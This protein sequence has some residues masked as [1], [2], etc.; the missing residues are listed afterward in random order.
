MKTSSIL[1]KNAIRLVALATIVAGFSGCLTKDLYEP[2]PEPEPEE[3]LF[4]DFA[5]S[6]KLPLTIDYGIAD[7]R[8]SFELYDQNPLITTEDDTFIK[9][10][11]LTPLFAA[12]TNWGSQYSGTIQLP[13]AVDKVYLYTDGF[14]VPNAHEIEVTSAGISFIQ[15]LA[16]STPSTREVDYTF[17]FDYPLATAANPYAVSSPL[18]KWNAAGRI[19]AQVN[20]SVI[21]G[22][23]T[24]VQQLAPPTGN[25][26]IYA[27]GKQYTNLV[28][29][30]EIVTHP[31]TGLIEG[32]T[33]IKVK[34]LWEFAGY[35]NTLGYYY[36]PK[37][38][39]MT[40]EAFKRLPKYIVFPNVSWNEVY[41]GNARA[42]LR[43]DYG[44]TPLVEGSSVAL[45]YYG[46]D[47]AQ[48]GTTL[49]PKDVEVGW[50]MMSDAFYTYDKGSTTRSHINGHLESNA[51]GNKTHLT[52]MGGNLMTGRP[53]SMYGTPNYLPYVFSNE[54]FNSNH[55]AGCITLYDEASNTVVIG[56][57]DG[58]ARS[59]Q[60]FLFYVE[61]TPGVINPGWDLTK[62]AVEPAM[63]SHFSGA[64]AFE[65]YWPKK[66]DYDLN[67]VI[68]NYHSTVVTDAD[69]HVIELIDTLKVVNDGADALYK[70]AFGYELGI[71]PDAIE[72]VTIDRKGAVSS[73]KVDAKGLELGQNGM[74]VVML[75]DNHKLSLG[76]SIVVHTKIKSSAAIKLGSGVMYPPYNPF[77]I[78]QASN[79]SGI[80]RKEIH[81][82]KTYRP[83]ALAGGLGTGD[84]VS[85][86]T[87]WYISKP[88]NKAIQYPFA[89][90]VPFD[91]NYRSFI[92]PTEGG[93]I[94]DQYPAFTDWVKSNGS[95]YKTWYKQHK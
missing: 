84:D 32:G 12:Y 40:Q 58:D 55:V 89:L 76:K 4:F 68:V 36:Y 92:F 94:N 61:A 21:Q 26:S 38:A 83:T 53:G 91:T 88:D 13:N 10:T 30:K 29:Y 78:A 11:G 71:L 49:F 72:S 80:G 6:T 69:N 28:T 8:V 52:Y 18:G 20:S 51:L 17:D 67:D 57:E 19:E 39:I 7:H 46:S 65:D 33:E 2:D 15:S 56:F 79:N 63:K 54:E 3:H 50:M 35:H 95:N 24:R 43:P 66:G 82:P 14:G 41:A 77:I 27:K 85:T 42:S 31:S 60:D 45:M 48:T 81:L 23:T 93:I 1:T 25:N 75:F 44:A 59:Y 47:H 70:N 90:H 62:K 5:S 87:I 86:P 22:L 64:L 34:F 37:G 9:V 74:A 16:T 73:F